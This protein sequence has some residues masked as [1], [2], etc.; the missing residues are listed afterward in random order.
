[1]NV[2]DVILLVVLIIGNVL[3]LPIWWRMFGTPLIRLFRRDTIAQQDRKR[4]T[5]ETKWTS[6]VPIQIFSW[7]RSNARTHGQ[8]V[9][10]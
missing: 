8:N 6:R 10:D 9:A 7:R 2:L 4:I 3:G 1:M 5:I